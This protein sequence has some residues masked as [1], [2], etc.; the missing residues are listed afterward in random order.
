M[1]VHVNTKTLAFKLQKNKQKNRKPRRMQAEM[2]SGSIC[3]GVYI[4]RRG[5][6]GGLGDWIEIN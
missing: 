6:G 3:A 5:G 1:T 2:A 4:L